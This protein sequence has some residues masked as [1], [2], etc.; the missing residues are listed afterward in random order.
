MKKS[1]LMLAGVLFFAAAAHADEPT[2]NELPGIL[3]K[4]RGCEQIHGIFTS[5]TTVCRIEEKDLWVSVSSSGHLHLFKSRNYGDTIYADGDSVGALLRDF[6]QRI[7]ADRDNGKVM[8]DMLAPY[9]P[10]Q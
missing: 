9:L 7:N 8:L 5:T 2:L 4:L 3:M 1:I 10:S 6:A